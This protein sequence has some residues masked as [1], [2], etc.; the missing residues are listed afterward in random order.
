MLYYTSNINEQYLKNFSDTTS[1]L[2]ICVSNF[3]AE[4]FPSVK[5]GNEKKKRK[6]KPMGK[7]YIHTFSTVYEQI[8][9]ISATLLENTKNW[10]F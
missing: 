5:W 8:R 7:K 3:S 4:P 2:S 1:G 10:I 6:E 9:Q